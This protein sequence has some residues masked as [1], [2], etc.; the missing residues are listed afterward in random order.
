MKIIFQLATVL[1]CSAAGFSQTGIGTDNPNASAVLDISS[2]NKGVLL[3][4]VSLLSNT[5]STTIINP[6]T[7]LIIWNTNNAVGTGAGI[8]VNNGTSALPNWSTYA[9]VSSTEGVSVKKT[10]YNSNNGIIGNS[11]ISGQLE[12]SIS[13][14][15]VPQVRLTSPMNAIVDF[16]NTQLWQGNNPASSSQLTFSRTFTTAN[17]NV[18]QSLAIDA[19]DSM[20]IG[21]NNDNNI[22]IRGLSGVAW[23]VHMW[24]SGVAP[25][26]WVIWVEKI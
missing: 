24:M 21:E 25:F 9:A 19:S 12:F 20:I 2:S 18:Y 4:R 11:V 22:T 14:S 7:G 1:L 16:N 8:Y 26:T 17:F 6:E 5:D 15:N 13:T 10:V 23:R 3:P